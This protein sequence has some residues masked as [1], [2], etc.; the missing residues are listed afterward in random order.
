LCTAIFAPHVIGSSLLGTGH[1]TTPTQY[2]TTPTLQPQPLI[3]QP[4][5]LIIQPHPINIQPHQPHPLII[6]PH[7]IN[8]QP[9][10]LNI[11]PHPLIKGGIAKYFFNHSF[12]TSNDMTTPSQYHNT[13]HLPPNTRY[14]THKHDVIVRKAFPAHTSSH[15]FFRLSH[16]S[17][18]LSTSSSL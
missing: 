12:R 1:A 3:I 9:H 4:H 2:P 13:T 15:L 16:D 7:P 8:I 18:N 11:K 6:Q 5:P 17:C 14:A 10:P